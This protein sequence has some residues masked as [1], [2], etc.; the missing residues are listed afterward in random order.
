M[1]GRRISLIGA[2]QS[3]LP[4]LLDLQFFPSYA[5]HL[6]KKKQLPSHNMPQNLATQ[7]LFER[8]WFLP[9]GDAPLSGM[10]S[11]DKGWIV[12]HSAA[13]CGPCKMLDI[14]LIEEIAARK[15]LTI[16]K[17]DV[18]QNEYTSGYLGVRSIPTFQFMVPKK[19]VDTIQSADT[20]K[21][22]EWISRL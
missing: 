8:M 16:W 13:W 14:R 1:E 4:P 7:E 12:W 10:R 15:G 6:G 22:M 20:T 11:S 5:L 9:P 18:D 21:V 3:D 2:T 17:C 19:I